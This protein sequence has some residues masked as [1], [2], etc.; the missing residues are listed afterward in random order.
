[1]KIMKTSVND[2]APMSELEILYL[3]AQKGLEDHG[4]E[5]SARRIVKKPGPA[6][7]CCTVSQVSER[8]ADCPWHTEWSGWYRDL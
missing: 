3:A 5:R 4:T 6:R 7:T 1:M 2:G 8:P